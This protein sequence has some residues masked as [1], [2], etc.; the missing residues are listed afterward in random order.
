VRPV[1]GARNLTVLS[2]GSQAP[3]L[4]FCSSAFPVPEPAAL[5]LDLSSRIDLP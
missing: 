3:T 4:Q 2:F 1:T 5:F